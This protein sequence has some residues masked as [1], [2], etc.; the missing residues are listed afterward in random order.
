MYRLF[1]KENILE[2]GIPLARSGTALFL[3]N[4][5]VE[6]GEGEHEHTVSVHGSLYP[7]I[8]QYIVPALTYSLVYLLLHTAQYKCFYILPGAPVFTYMYSPF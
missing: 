5:M 8:I 2:S 1:S 7:R 6:S 3:F 4:Q